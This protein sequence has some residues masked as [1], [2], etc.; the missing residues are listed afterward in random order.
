MYT[1]VEIINLGLAK[2]SQSKIRRIDPPESSLERHCELVYRNARRTEL[3]KRRWVFATVEDFVLPLAETL[4][5]GSR[6]YKYSIPTDCLRPIRTRSTE[7]IQR[8]R[9]IFS[10]YSSLSIP[11]I[12][13]VDEADFDPLFI[14][15]LSAR[16]AIESAEFVTQ[17]RSKREDATLAYDLAVAEAAQ[18][19]AF[20]I[21]AED[22]T[23][24]D[25]DFPF[26]T[27]RDP[28]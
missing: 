12:Q 9:F 17:S 16:V 15:V 18:A 19:N 27:G 20:V 28:R 2:L 14:D 13:N 10:A 23:N 6:K 3:T 26:L 7:W 5:S 21:G 22:I 1:D 24:E 25:Y 4:T 8:G 11:Y